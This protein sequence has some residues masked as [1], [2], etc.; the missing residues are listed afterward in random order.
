MLTHAENVSEHR[1]MYQD[2]LRSGVIRGR[3][4]KRTGTYWLNGMLRIYDPERC[5]W[6]EKQQ[7]LEM[8]LY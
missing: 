1:E 3:N 6:D 8:C 5:D 7:H 2:V 4:V